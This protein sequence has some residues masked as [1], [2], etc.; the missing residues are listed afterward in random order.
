[1]NG[2][3]APIRDMKFALSALARRDEMHLYLW[4]EN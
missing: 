3:V 4:F 1:M 2:Y